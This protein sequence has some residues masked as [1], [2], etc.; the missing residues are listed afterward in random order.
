MSLGDPRQSNPVLSALKVNHNDRIISVRENVDADS[1]FILT[2]LMKQIF[3]EKNKLCLVNFH[4]S[5]E[6]YENIGRKLG[7]DLLQAVEDKE[8]NI[9]DPLNGIT[10]CIGLDEDYFR[11]DKDNIVKC[12]YLDIRKNLEQLLVHGNHQVYLVIDDLSHLSD[13]AV[14]ISD[15]ITFV[16]YC[17]NLINNDRICV[18]L[19]NH[20]SSDKDEIVSNNLQYIADAHIE[21]SSLKTGKSIDVTGFLTIERN[22][23][24][25]QYQYK[26]YDRGIKTFRPGEAIYHLY[27]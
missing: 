13:L 8:A 6:H 22:S 19:N 1:N 14:E 3:F 18:I 23:E 7:Y 24:K 2:H 12:L 16:H 21:I 26:A 25:S 11:E 10:E 20:V 27:R 15:I 17:I 9:I 5:L 4:H